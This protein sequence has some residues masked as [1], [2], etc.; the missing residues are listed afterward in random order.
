MR[1]VDSREDS[2][3]LTDTRVETLTGTVP[4]VKGLALPKK[5]KD[6]GKLTTKQ[7]AWVKQQVERL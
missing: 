6:P 4:L 2:L 1:V 7:C 5:A 3:L